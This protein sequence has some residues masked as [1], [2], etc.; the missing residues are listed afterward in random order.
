VFARRYPALDRIDGI[1]TA[2]KPLS[3]VVTAR[4]RM[5]CAVTFNGTSPSILTFARLSIC[6]IMR[7]W[8]S[9]MQ[10]RRRRDARS[11]EMRQFGELIKS[12]SDKDVC[13]FYES[14][15]M[16]IALETND[17]FRRKR[18]ACLVE[19]KNRATLSDGNVTG[20]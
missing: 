18:D 2:T 20:G 19:L 6:E 15:Q 9:T 7:A 4:L 12:V 1:G 11:A 16:L 17:Q 8:L 13:Q 10:E 3:A 14:Y 5:N